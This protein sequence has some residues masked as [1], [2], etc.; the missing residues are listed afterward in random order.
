MPET[1]SQGVT[2]AHDLESGKPIECRENIMRL[3]VPQKRDSNHWRAPLSY[4]NSPI[5]EP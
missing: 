5:N 3:D 1:T 4:N 2:S